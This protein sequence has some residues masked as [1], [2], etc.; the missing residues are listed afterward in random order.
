M[1]KAT[2][3]NNKNF[4]LIIFLTVLSLAPAFLRGQESAVDRNRYEDVLYLK[5]GSVLKGRLHHYVKG[6]IIVFELSTGDVLE[7][8]QSE[9]KRFVQGGVA[10]NPGEVKGPKPYEFKEEGVYFSFALGLG[11]G[12]NS[13][14][15]NAVAPDLTAGAGYHFSRWLGLGGGFG[16]DVYAPER[17]EI[18]YPI[19]GEI[20]GY[21]LQARQSPYYAFRSGYGIAVKDEDNRVL[22]AKGGWYV[23]PSLGLRWGASAG[24]NFV[25]EVGLQFQRAEY[26][27][28]FGAPG[29][30]E[31]Q[32][33]QYKRLIFRL[34][35]VF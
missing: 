21:L 26:T 3:M 5:D 2:A 8:T 24:V 27:R 20:R 17:S 25:T 16:V 35:I 28:A 32:S 13:R 19:F 14:N 12:R 23:N 34:G 6:E 22:E 33:R 29:E 30:R 18:I 4:S 7:Y 15:E 31:I 11:I 1:P 9:I 10:A